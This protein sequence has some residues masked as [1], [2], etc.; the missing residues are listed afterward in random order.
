MR[1]SEQRHDANRSARGRLSSTRRRLSEAIAG[2]DKEGSEALF[3]Q[4]CAYLDKA[5]K[6]GA[7]K[8]NNA[9]R[10]KSRAA[11]SMATLS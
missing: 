7:I 6:Q 4:Y 8:A 5:V 11:A 1:T 9:S 10:N 3:R 2:S